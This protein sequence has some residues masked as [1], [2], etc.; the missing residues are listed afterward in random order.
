MARK[1]IAQSAITIIAV[2]SRV[3]RQWNYCPIFAV[4]LLRPE[5]DDKPSGFNTAEEA[6]AAARKDK[7]I[8]KGSRFQ[9]QS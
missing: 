5:Y 4:S 2:Q 8:P 1:I 7:S 6:L 3:T 9:V